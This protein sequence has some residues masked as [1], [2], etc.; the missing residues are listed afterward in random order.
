[1]GSKLDP[2]KLRLECSYPRLNRFVD[3]A[4][5]ELWKC[6]DEVSQRAIRRDSPLTISQRT[7]KSNCRVPAF[8]E[9][10]VSRQ[11]RH[12]IYDTPTIAGKAKNPELRM[13][14]SG[15]T[16]GQALHDTAFQKFELRK[17]RPWQH[18]TPGVAEHS[19]FV[20]VTSQALQQ[21][22]GVLVKQ[23]FMPIDVKETEGDWCRQEC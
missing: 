23:V 16:L 20:C 22:E 1:M 13:K 5:R 10:Q 8:V 2:P 19:Q 3:T 12:A 15:L 17:F 7:L 18:N 14:R 4:V 6:S 9:R 21:R 11:T